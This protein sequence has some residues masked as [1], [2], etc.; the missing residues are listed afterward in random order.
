MLAR[1]AV[2]HVAPWE[3]AL[4]VGLLLVSIAVALLFAARV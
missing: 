3:F 4:A 1:L 2:G